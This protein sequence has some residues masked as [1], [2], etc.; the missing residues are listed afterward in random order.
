MSI[1]LTNTEYHILA[2]IGAIGFVVGLGILTRAI[3]LHNDTPVQP[4]YTCYNNHMYYVDKDRVMWPQIDV[5][6]K[7]KTCK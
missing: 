6:M 3:Y 5:D 7:A 2:T 4:Y 1:K